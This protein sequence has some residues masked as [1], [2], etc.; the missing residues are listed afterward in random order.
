MRVAGIHLHPRLGLRPGI[1]HLLRLVCHP[2]E[3]LPHSADGGGD[4]PTESGVRSV[5]R[6]EPRGRGID[7]GA[8]QAWDIWN[9]NHEVAPVYWLW[10]KALTAEATPE[11]P[12]PMAFNVAACL[13]DLPS[14]IAILPF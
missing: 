12:V 13:M 8:L 10:P 3:I 5:R 6:L 14:Y 4:G 1:L 11:I 7:L 2:L 9:F